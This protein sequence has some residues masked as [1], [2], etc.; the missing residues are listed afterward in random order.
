M[1]VDNQLNTL[2]VIEIV[3][4]IAALFFSYENITR[5]LDKLFMGALGLLTFISIFYSITLP[6][7]KEALQNVINLIEKEK[8]NKTKK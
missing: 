6:R 8:E 2:I 3:V 1:K 4:F 5:N 7:R